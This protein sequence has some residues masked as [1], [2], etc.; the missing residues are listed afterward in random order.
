MNE[1][2]LKQLLTQL[3]FAPLSDT[4][5]STQ[6]LE[7]G[8]QHKVVK[9]QIDNGRALVIKELS[10][11]CYFG[12]YSEEHF[13]ACETYAAYVNKHLGSAVVAYR[14]TNQYVLNETNKSYLIY[15]WCEGSVRYELTAEQAIILGQ[16]LAKLHALPMID[17]PLKPIPFTPFK[18]HLWAQLLEKNIL[19][20]NELADLITLSKQCERARVNYQGKRVMS[21]R[22]LNLENI[23]WTSYDKFYLID[24][25]SSGLIAP[26]I[27]LIGLAINLGG[28]GQAQLNM[29]LLKSTIDAYQKQANVY[30]KMTNDIFIQCYATWF[31]WL[32]YCLINLAKYPMLYRNE[33]DLTIQAIKLIKNNQD[34][35]IR[36]F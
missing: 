35:I 21:H 26:L 32:D 33:I 11:S 30:D 25:E 14:A 8:R 36:Y 13:N 19:S 18:S 10:F 27:D 17:L 24:W 5:I 16:Y 22:D 12:E 7:G 23:L 15:P 20:K 31:S 1:F 3:Q 34:N 4:S 9:A 29:S 2:L 6:K 28:I